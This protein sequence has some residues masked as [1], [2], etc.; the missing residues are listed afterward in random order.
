MAP[1]VGHFRFESGHHGDRW[2]EPDLLLKKPAVLR[3]FAERLA[4]RLK[5]YRFEAVCGPLTG[6]AFLAQ[7]VADRCNVSFA[8]AERFAPPSNEM[9]PVTYRIPHA[10]RG[11]LSGLAV[12]IVNDVTNAGSAVRGTFADLVACGA[13]PVAL[14]T[15]VVLGSWSSLFAAENV[16][17]LE[18]LETLHNNLWLPDDCP[19]CASSSPLEDPSTWK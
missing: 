5:P 6:G 7:L 8:F 11:D 18:S 17:G 10:L 9:Y 3:P 4:D 15:L 1:R 14:G 16:L 12:A 19:L 13:K 2:L